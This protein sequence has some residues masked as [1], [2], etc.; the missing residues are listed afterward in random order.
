MTLG[1]SSNT[2]LDAIFDFLPYFAVPLPWLWLWARFYLFYQ[3]I[4]W[5]SLDSRDWWCGFKFPTGVL[6]QT[7]DLFCILTPTLR[8]GPD[9]PI[10]AALQN[11]VAD[12]NP[13]SSHLKHAP[14]GRSTTDSGGG[15][16][17]PTLRRTHLWVRGRLHKHMHMARSEAKVLPT[18]HPRSGPP[19]LR[20]DI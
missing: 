12:P 6:P 1:Q 3:T 20:P 17:V 9:R 13:A 2:A 7:E 14:L 15:E 10:H 4:R 16:Y 19:T 8:P 5:R 11:L 18:L